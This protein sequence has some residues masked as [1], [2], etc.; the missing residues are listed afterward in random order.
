MPINPTYPGVYIDELTSS[1]HTIIG[2]PTSVTA[3]VGAAPRGPNDQPVH[4]GS[5]GD[6][7]R[8]FGGVSTDSPMSY[9]VYQFYNNGGSEAEI[10]RLTHSDAKPATIDLGNNVKLQAANPGDWGNKLRVRVT[11]NAAPPA[12]AAAAAPAAGNGAPAAGNGAPAAGN[13]APAAGNGAPAAGNAAPAGDA[14]AAPAAAPTSYNLAVRDTGTGT[15]ENYLNISTDTSNARSLDKLLAGSTLVTLPPNPKLDTAPPAS[16]PIKPT[17]TDSDPFSDKYPGR[18]KQ[19][20]GGAAGAAPDLGDYQ[21]GNTGQADKKGIYQLY[22][23]DIFNLLC[24]P[25]APQQLLAANAAPLCVERRAI[26]LVDPPAAWSSVANAVTGMNAPPVAGTDAANAAVYFPNVQIAD[27][28]SGGLPTTV[29]PCG[30]IA[31]VWKAPAGTDASLNAVTALD[32]PLT[33]DDSGQLNPLGVNCLRSFNIIGPVVWGA[34]TLRGADVLTDQWK[35]LPVR[36]LALFIEESL[37]RGTQWVVFEPNDEPLW[38]AIRLNVGA[39]MHD[40]FQQ[41]AF[42]GSTAD[43]AYLVKCDKENNPQSDIDKGIV[44]I[45]VGFA[46]LK[47]AEFVIIHIEQLAGQLQ[48]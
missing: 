8:I 20:S 30:T 21:G 14:A 42:Q 15:Q 2:V 45:L 32:M 6:Y 26:L 9:A 3:F 24:L 18:Y 17:D 38:A 7:Q 29:P 33:D 46:P 11:S 16:D 4:I 40:L 28:A 47:P 37:F 48:T 1:V 36:R 39:F 10:V 27:P 31:G 19:G 35:Y 13:G 43:Q 23:T 44:N 12:A 5:F 25:G 41:G 34:R 22:K